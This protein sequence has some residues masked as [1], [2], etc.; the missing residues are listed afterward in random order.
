MTFTSPDAHKRIDVVGEKVFLRIGNRKFPTGINNVTKHDAEL[1]WAPD[2]T[3]FFVTWSESGELGPWH[4][5]VYGIDDSGVHE[6]P[7]VEEPA[8]KDFERRVRHWPIDRRVNTPELRAIWD[9]KDYCEPY[10]VIGGR[11]LNGSGEILLSVLVR[12]TSDCKYMSEFNVYRVD[13]VTGKILDRFTA[14]EGHQR[15]GDE[16][17][18]LIAR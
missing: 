18:P 7:K 17:L 6:F 14:V 12:N 8:R 13:A 16:Y 11:W 10:D 4:M 15:F 2:S 5:Q 3:K 9:G 1:G